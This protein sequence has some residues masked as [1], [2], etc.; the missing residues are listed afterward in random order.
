MSDKPAAE[1]IER[2]AE[3]KTTVDGF[4]VKRVYTRDDIKDVKPEDINEQDE[5][6]VA[7]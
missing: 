2:K 7:C 4:P 1:P 3:F 5:Y 6:P